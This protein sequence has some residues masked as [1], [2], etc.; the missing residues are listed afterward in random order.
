[1]LIIIAGPD[2]HAHY[3]FL[4]ILI[5][6]VSVYRKFS[7]FYLFSEF[8]IYLGLWRTCTL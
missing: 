7:Q 6:R 1:M 8:R 5:I 3:N 4:V 2:T